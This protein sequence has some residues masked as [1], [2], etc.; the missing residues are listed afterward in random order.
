MPL[1]R[2]ASTKQ[3]AVRIGFIRDDGAP[4]VRTFLAWAAENKILPA[5]GKRHHLWWDFNA[6]ESAL[7]NKVDSKSE[8]KDWKKIITDN[9]NKRLVAHGGVQ[10]EISAH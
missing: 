6:I 2:F 3:A 4:N 10:S 9:I 8:L 5:H 1:P 7:D